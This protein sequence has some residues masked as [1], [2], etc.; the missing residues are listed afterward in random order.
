MITLLRA[1]HIDTRIAG[2]RILAADVYTLNGS[3]FTDWIDITDWSRP[4][5]LAWLGY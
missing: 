5:L 4:Q 3:L 1:H 2:G